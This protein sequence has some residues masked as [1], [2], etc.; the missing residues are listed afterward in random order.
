MTAN[1][2]AAITTFQV[3]TSFSSTPLQVCSAKLE[4]Q[5]DKTKDKISPVGD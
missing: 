1:K 2:H 4:K 3:S 5:D